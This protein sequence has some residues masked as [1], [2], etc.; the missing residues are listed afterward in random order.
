MSGRWGKKYCPNGGTRRH[1]ETRTLLDRDFVKWLQEN[2]SDSLRLD[3]PMVRHTTFRVGGEADAYVAVEDEIELETLVCQCVRSWVPYLIL[4]GGTNLL[5]KDGGLRGVVIDIKKGLQT[6]STQKQE[7]GGQ[8]LAAGAGV[9]LQVLCRF[10]IDNGLV[11]LNFALGIPGTVGGA[12]V[13]NAGT[14][15]GNMADV[16]SS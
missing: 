3:E 4:A 6:I 1:Q 7:E 16:I 15:R 11:G 5:V 9:N 8:L 10:A 12:T 13:M 14:H 2:F